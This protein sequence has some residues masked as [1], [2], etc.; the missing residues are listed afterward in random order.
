[1][2][3]TNILSQ[4]ASPQ[5]R[6]PVVVA[7]H[8]CVNKIHV[9]NKQLT[10]NN[11]AS[12]QITRPHPSI[13]Q[14]KGQKVSNSKPQHPTK[15]TTPPQNSLKTKITPKA[16]Q[17]ADLKCLNFKLAVPPPKQDHTKNSCPTRSS[18]PPTLFFTQG[19]GPQTRKNLNLGKTSNNPKTNKI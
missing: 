3:I 2:V 5:V 8:V 18:Q 9:R 7:I 19:A 1:M 13:Q 15:Q 12:S 6:Q 16:S 11:P 10:T 14:H 17:T 4:K